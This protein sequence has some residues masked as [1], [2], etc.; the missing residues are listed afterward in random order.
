[1]REQAARKGLAIA[2]LAVMLGACAPAGPIEID[3]NSFYQ[4]PNQAGQVALRAGDE[5]TVRLCSNPSTGYQWAEEAEI[6]DTDVL[7]QKSH[8]YQAPAE[9]GGPPAPGTPGIEVWVFRAVK[10]GE[11]TIR[12]EY[13]QPWDGGDKATWTFELTIEVK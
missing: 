11:S 7:V 13:S 4:D 9:E 1:M 2:M 12:L 5:I 8:A 3:C 10:S 6:G